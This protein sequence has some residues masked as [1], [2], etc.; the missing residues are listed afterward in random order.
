MKG[1]VLLTVDGGDF[2]VFTSYMD[3][4]SVATKI[5]TRFIASFFM[6]ADKIVLYFFFL[7]DNQRIFLPQLITTL[8]MK[9]TTVNFV[10]NLKL[11]V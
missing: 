6:V 8:I 11:S 4:G 5:R 7:Q 3:H 1:Q 10:Q 9:E 2:A